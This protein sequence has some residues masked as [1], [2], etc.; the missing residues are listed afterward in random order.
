[1]ERRSASTDGS[2]ERESRRAPAWTSETSTAGPLPVEDDGTVLRFEA[3]GAASTAALP[4]ALVR[5]FP[6]G[7]LPLM[8]GQ[9]SSDRPTRAPEKGRPARRTALLRFARWTFASGPP[10]QRT[11]TPGCSVAVASTSSPRDRST[12]R[13]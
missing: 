5:V 4:G 12:P 9:C 1:A 2:V 6:P 10:S 11:P 7:A 8:P 3:L 13:R